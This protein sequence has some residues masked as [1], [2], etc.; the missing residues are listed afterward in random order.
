D[1]QTNPSFVLDEEKGYYVVGGGV[2]ATINHVGEGKHY[3]SAADHSGSKPWTFGPSSFHPGVVNHGMADC[4]AKSV[5]LN[6]D[7][8]LYMHLISRAGNEPVN[9]FHT[10]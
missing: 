4:S 9:K 8:T 10:D 1:E 6:I 3:L 5:S 7:P 2:A